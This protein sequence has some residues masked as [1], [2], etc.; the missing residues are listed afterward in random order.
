MKA[1]NLT[2]VVTQSPCLHIDTAELKSVGLALCYQVR[3]EFGHGFRS[4][5]I[6]WMTANSVPSIKCV[7]VGNGMLIRS[8]LL[9]DAA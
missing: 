1:L 7:N 5:L 4:G 6:R 2:R 9:R 3:S 8:L